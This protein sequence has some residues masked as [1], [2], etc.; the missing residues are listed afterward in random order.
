MLKKWFKLSTK[1]VHVVRGLRLEVPYDKSPCLSGER[2][3]WLKGQDSSAC[4]KASS[5]DDKTKAT[6][7]A[8]LE[9]AASTDTNPYMRDIIASNYGEVCSTKADTVG[10]SVDVKGTCWTHVHS[11]LY[12]IYDFTYW[13]LEHPGNEDKIM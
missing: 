11:D 7:A 4:A 10:M 8:A 9:A 13:T 3:R 6:V 5:V 12:S 1:H 2:S